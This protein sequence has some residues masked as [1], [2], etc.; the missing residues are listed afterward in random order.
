VDIIREFLKLQVLLSIKVFKFKLKFKT[1]PLQTLQL[2][3]TG[4]NV[5]G[6]YLL[7]VITK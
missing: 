4:E 3:E 1:L 6:L 5:L 2:S 7:G